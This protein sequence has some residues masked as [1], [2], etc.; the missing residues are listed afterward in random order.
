MCVGTLATY[1]ANCLLG[2]DGDRLWLASPGRIDLRTEV[3]RGNSAHT[4]PAPG[5]MM[6]RRT[7]DL[8]WEAIPLVR[9]QACRS[10]SEKSAMSSRDTASRRKTLKKRRTLSIS[11][12]AKCFT[13]TACFSAGRCC[14]NSAS[15]SR[16]LGNDLGELFGNL[17]ALVQQELHVLLGNL[18]HQ[19]I[20]FG[21][22]RGRARFPR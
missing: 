11:W 13:S 6:P 21:F 15:C 16:R 12:A 19:R 3:T 8:L 10:S 2:G 7:I 14:I 1:R 17:R 4:S 22:H 18:I 20:G 5:V 9:H